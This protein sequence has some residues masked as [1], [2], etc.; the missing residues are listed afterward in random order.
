MVGFRMESIVHDLRFALRQLRK[1]PGFTL[2]AIVTLAL[3]I[4]ASVAIFAFVDAA[5]IKPLPYPNPSRLAGVSET[6]SGRLGMPLSYADYLDWKRMNTVFQSMDV[7]TQT[8]YLLKTGQGVQPESGIRVSAGF[9]KTLGISPALGRDFRDG[10]DAVGAPL[11]V[12][13][14]DNAWRKWFGG[15]AD[16]IGQTVSLSGTPYTVI[17]VLPR[18]FQFAPRNRADFWAALQPTSDCEKRRGCHSL[19]GLGR[20]KDGAS[21]QTANENMKSI[22]AQLERLYPG[23]NNGQGAD[24]EL[25]SEA[26]VGKIRPIL[27]VLLGGAALLLLIACVNVSSLLL[28][29]T[30]S[31][32]RELAV[33]G[34]LGASRGRV[35]RQF[36]TEGVALVLMGSVLGVCAAYGAMRLMLKLISEDMLASMP[37]LKDLGMNAR[38]PAFAFAVALLAAVLFSVTPALRLSRSGLRDD[39]A[40]GSRGSA[41]MTWRRFG[42]NLVVLELAIAMVLLVGAGLLGK[43]FYRLLHVDVGFPVDH[44]AS[45]EVAMPDAGYT[46]PEQV[47]AAEEQ[48]LSRIQSVPGVKAVGHTSVLPVSCNCNTDWVRFP[49]RP[50]HGEHNEVNERDISSGYFQTLGARLIRGRLFTD[51]DATGKPNVIIVSQ[52][53]ARLY[54]PGQ[55]PIGQKIGDLGLSPGSMRQ[56]VGVVNDVHEGAL[57]DDLWPTE[58]EPYRQGPDTQ[59]EVVVRT[60]RPA[61]SVFPELIAAVHKV[62]PGIGTSDE[63]TIEDRNNSSYSAYLHRASA[64]IVGGF[65]ALALLLGVVGL[66]GVVAYSV[67]QRTREIGVRMALGAQRGTVYRLILTE[68]G[69]LTAIGIAAGALCAVGAGALM[70]TMLFGVHTWDTPTVVGVGLVLGA[71]AAVA[72]YL[73][74]RRAASVNPVE[75]LRAE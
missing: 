58:Y 32:R 70:R 16:A 6:S 74:A 54:F 34:A 10:E 2:T 3:G 23:S 65:A 1:N 56:I 33:R 44:L 8:G 41:G 61:E 26:I 12:I 40:E 68:A 75:A 21:L 15:K 7:W 9:L 37:Y 25:F 63:V 29:R 64:W 38:V 51:A 48:I 60:L 62:D 50:Y 24:I 30:E 67:S 22:A 66:Y 69:W 39:L 52:E 20:L 36:V 55:D 28:V 19:N 17:G 18:A 71:A 14:S 47:L 31:R 49:G 4:C 43:S 11:T 35:I 27:E 53:F 45:F 72:S 42:S 5:L 46:K 73:P 59:F 57:D 13:L